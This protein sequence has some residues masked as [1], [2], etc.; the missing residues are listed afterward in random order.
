MEKN[1]EAAFCIAFDPPIP[2]DQPE[3]S[4]IDA[5]LSSGV[6]V[7][8]NEAFARS[9]GAE[10]CSVLIGRPLA[11]VI[12]SPG[13]DIRE[14]LRIFIRG[15]FQICGQEMRETEYDG[16]RRVFL[17]DLVG[18]VDQGC[19]TQL[20]SMRRDITR[21]KAVE[22]DLR[23]S[24]ER[25]RSL[26][27]SA[28]DIFFTV[29]C[30]GNL[31]YWNSALERI[32]GFHR[33]EPL[34]LRQIVAPRY[35]EGVLKLIRSEMDR[36]ITHL[37]VDIE[38][39]LGKTVAVDLGLAQLTIPG[40]PPGV[41]GIGRNVNARK[42]TER[43]EDARRTI[44]EMVARDAPIDAILER[45]SRIVDEHFPGCTA[46]ISRASGG[47]LRYVAGRLPKAFSEAFAGTRIGPMSLSC[48]TAAF[49]E[50]VVVASNIST[51]PTW[52][53]L[54]PVTL[55]HGLRACWSS[56][57]IGSSGKVLGTVAIYFPDPAEVDAGMMDLLKSASELAAVTIEHHSF[58][59][60]LRYRGTHDPV[61]ALPNRYYLEDRLRHA[62]I[63]AG[64]NRF[65]VM[66]LDLD[67]FKFINDTY[68]HMVGDELMRQIAAR[69]A[70]CIA[71]GDIL[72]RMGGDEFVILL[73]DPADAER[74]DE[75]AA[76]IRGAFTS[77]VMA[78]G[79]ELFVGLSIGISV[80]PTDGTQPEVLLA[81]AD[82][83]LANAK[84]SGKGT[85]RLFT[86]AM[87]EHVRQRL[88]LGNELH[89]A[90]DRNELS[91]F[92]QPQFN[93]QNGRLVGSEALLR[94]HSRNHGEV[95][96][97]EFIPIAEESGLIIPIGE[98]VMREACA[99][100][101]KLQ[102]SRPGPVRVAVNVS[103]V[104]LAQPDF[105]RSVSRI[106]EETGLA[107]QLLELEITETALMRNPGESAK[108]IEE[109]RELGLIIT[110][111]DFGT[112]YSSL[113][114][115]QHLSVDSLKI[116]LSFVREI[117]KIGLVPPIIQAIVALARGLGVSTVAEGVE[118]R[119]QLQVLRDA[120]CDEAQGFLLGFPLPP[121][122]IVERKHSGLFEIG[123][124]DHI[125]R[126]NPQWS[127]AKKLVRS[128]QPTKLLERR[129]S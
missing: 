64:E 43:F 117:K 51:D 92:Y 40:A 84:S 35:L 21:L 123:T 79:R 66:Y 83:A 31:T 56:P 26:F 50:R 121:G 114:R 46:A 36:G 39:A 19:L 53:T 41:L 20:W 42:A 122:A 5:I 13:G 47:K 68:G 102:K 12:S 85:F 120:G 78:M 127:E 1:V 24:E 34:H 61:T 15:G 105:V 77:P 8:C 75:V 57:V 9:R 63:E 97:A 33:G 115:L 93:L 119:E 59:E 4:Q 70:T 7:D 82:A 106:L 69:L 55:Q 27:D 124:S 73:L 112:G 110:V 11:D 113:S 67:S 60:E 18:L 94:W 65:S 6:V 49:L 76:A 89:R 10:D 80:Y 99:H 71:P 48:G 98:W 17:A 72:G 91:I 29:D 14:Y 104:Q 58:T 118:N 129:Q 100:A 38:T 95:T 54:A 90:L 37:E 74:P 88:K 32:T 81:N 2:V 125:A 128:G 109:L 52:T 28:N 16:R 96:P 108:N 126:V 107:P 111:D 45:L 30:D 25:Y 101:L 87:L 116:D 22:D 44:M 62:A 86:P 23:R 3:G 103:A